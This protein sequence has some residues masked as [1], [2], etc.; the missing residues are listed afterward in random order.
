MA[1]GTT[2]VNY[3]TDASTG[4]ASSLHSGFFTIIKSDV[5]QLTKAA[6]QSSSFVIFTT[7]LAATAFFAWATVSNASPL[8]TRQIPF[9]LNDSSGVPLWQVTAFYDAS[10]GR[11]RFDMLSY[12]AG[13]TATTYVLSIRYYLLKEALS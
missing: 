4:D 3:I 5:V 2:S 9:Q 10:V 6:T 7:P 8:L 11:I 1:H 12:D 13:V